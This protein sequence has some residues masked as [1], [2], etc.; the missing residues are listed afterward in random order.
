MTMLNPAPADDDLD[1]DD[2]DRDALRRALKIAMKDPSEAKRLQARLDAGEPW[3]QVAQSVVY[4][5]QYAALHLCPWQSPPVWD[6]GAESSALLDEMLAHNIS[7]YEPDPAA[8]LRKA[9]RR[10]R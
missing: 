5:L 9:K 8:A 2:V 1:L 3:T 10:R 6:D 7:Q 4:G